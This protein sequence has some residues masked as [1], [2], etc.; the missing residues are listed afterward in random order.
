VY[1]KKREIGSL[2]DSRC[3]ERSRRIAAAVKLLVM[4]AIL[5]CDVVRR[6]APF[7]GEYAFSM[8]MVPFLATSTTPEKPLSRCASTIASSRAAVS[9]ADAP[10][11]AS[12]S[13]AALSVK[14]LRKAP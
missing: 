12:D 4:D 11:A 13:S 8:M 6:G 7:R 10:G 2:K 14:T 3:V 1:G 5:N 9:C